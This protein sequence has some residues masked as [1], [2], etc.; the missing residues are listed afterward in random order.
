ML[1]DKGRAS[2][3][4][5]VGTAYIAHDITVP[6]LTCTDTSSS[7]LLGVVASQRIAQKC[8]NIS[9]ELAETNTY[10]NRIAMTCIPDDAG[11]SSAAIAELP[12]IPDD[13]HFHRGA[14]R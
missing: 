4:I 11:C 5:G 1:S 14:G 6:V 13:V 12:H 10:H 8:C 9:A 2:E 3:Q 7:S